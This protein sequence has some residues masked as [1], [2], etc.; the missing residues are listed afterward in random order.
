MEANVGYELADGVATVTL[1]DGKVNALS[2]DMLSQI[3]A[4]LDRAEADGAVVVLVGR[5][6]IFSGGFDLKVLNAGG[7]DARAMLAGGFRLAE[8]MLGFPTPIVVACTGHAIAMGLFLVQAADYRIGADG[9]FRITANEV[10]IGL[11]LPVIAVELLKLRC[12][13]AHLQRAANL[14]EVFSPSD[15]VTAGLLDSIVPAGEVRSAADTAARGFLALDM[16]AHAGTK[17]LVRA[18]ALAAIHAAN[19]ADY[20]PA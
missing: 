14:A 8:R 13:P 1:D 3:G 11:T 15:A 4:A 6:G 18:P 10:A 19:E 16:R 5:E 17:R 7:G 20:G 9:P 12:T 2:L